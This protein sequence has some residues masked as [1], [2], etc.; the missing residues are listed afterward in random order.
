MTV[1]LKMPCSSGKTKSTVTSAKHY[2]TE[3]NVDILKTEEHLLYF[4]NQS[5]INQSELTL[6]LYKCE[7]R[8]LEIH[9]GMFISMREK[10]NIHSFYRSEFY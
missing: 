9:F 4:Y 7:Y 6:H 8:L 2:V 10:K 1:D 3:I 5:A